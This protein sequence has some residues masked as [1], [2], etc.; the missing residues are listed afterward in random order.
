MKGISEYIKRSTDEYSSREDVEWSNFW[1]DYANDSK[2][3]RIL[4]V[5][6][7]TARRIRS[8]FSQSYGIAVDLLG[9]SAGLHDILFKSQL[10]AFFVS[11][12]Y[13]YDAIYVQLG[14][15]GIITDLGAEIKKEDDYIFKED[16][17]GLVDFLLQYT[18]RIILLSI[19]ESVLVPGKQI[20]NASLNAIMKKIV[21][22]IMPMRKNHY[23]SKVN[24][25]TIR[26]NK[27]I[28]EIAKE[29]K[30]IY[31]DINRITKDADYRHIDNIHFVKSANKFISK[32]YA[33][34]IE[35]LI[36]D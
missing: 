15:H 32:N 26:R 5:G 11:N 19:F 8:T 3:K 1:Y 35:D 25:I 14:T 10:E 7:S 4:L 20:K 2:K 23:D 30:L 34:L 27:I 36:F 13:S 21:R 24:E 17:K 28:A 18:N 31:F 22:M 16:Y 33:S 9:T 29:Y 12:K 6:D